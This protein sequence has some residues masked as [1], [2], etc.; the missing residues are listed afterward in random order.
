[1]PAAGEAPTATSQPAGVSP[2]KSVPKVTPKVLDRGT[3][4]VEVKEVMDGESTTDHIAEFLFIKQMLLHGFTPV[5]TPEQARYTIKGEIECKY[6]KQVTF[7]FGGQSQHLEHQYKAFAQVTLTDNK[8][9]EGSEESEEYFD[10]PEPGMINGRTEKDDAKRDIRRYAAT[11]LS[12]RLVAG[13]MLLN[14]EVKQ[15]EY[16]LGDPFE[17]RTFNDVIGSYVEIG[18]RAVPYLLSLIL[19]DR[20]V[21]LKGDYPGLT[22]E[23]AQELRYYHIADRALGDI[24][25]R[26][27]AL[28]LDSSEDYYKKVI[29]GWFWA[30]EDEQGIPKEYQTSPKLREKTVPAPTQG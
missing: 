12:E 24:L 6:H 2:G 30:W 26:D 23:T 9:E 29:T 13:K 27:S 7:D 3:F 4:Y 19:D 11:K 21:K 5:S 14:A 22:G 18:H 17:E 16:A 28:Q 8:A 1:M 15:L 20:P 25:L 10:V